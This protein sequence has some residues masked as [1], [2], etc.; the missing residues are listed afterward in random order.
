MSYIV[1]HEVSAYEGWSPSGE[2]ETLD[3]CLDFVTRN[4]YGSK[5]VITSPVSVRLVEDL[6][7]NGDKA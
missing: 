5:Y 4:T 3:Q 7:M 2:L 1:W 6:T